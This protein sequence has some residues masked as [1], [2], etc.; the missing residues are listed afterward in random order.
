MPKTKIYSNVN[1]L[2]NNNYDIKYIIHLADIHIRNDRL[3]EYEL[4]FETLYK[5]LKNRNLNRTNSV[6]CIIGDIFHS[7]QINAIA[8]QT[9]KNFFYKLSEITSLIVT[10]GNHD[11]KQ[12]NSN[13]NNL[14]AIIKTNFASL[15]K[16]FYI[17]QN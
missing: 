11:V 17:E 1:I 10:Y 7:T 3:C 13:L 15:N 16:I 4:V 2:E 14:S 5:D 8:I 6:C 9:C 12:N